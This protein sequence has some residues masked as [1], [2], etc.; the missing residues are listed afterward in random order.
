MSFTD[1]DT[2][3]AMRELVG[4]RLVK[5]TDELAEY[6]AFNRSHDMPAIESAAE[7]LWS[8][9]CDLGLGGGSVAPDFREREPET[10]GAT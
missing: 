7:H 4:E 5:A 8:I 9:R 6:L 2:L 10:D 1:P 3:A